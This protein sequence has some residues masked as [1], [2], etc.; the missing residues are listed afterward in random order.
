M[1]LG[2]RKDK[3]KALT[4]DLRP[5]FK[6]TTEEYQSEI[7]DLLK[8]V[9]KVKAGVLEPRDVAVVNNLYDNLHRLRR[10]IERT[11]LSEHVSNTFAKTAD[12]VKRSPIG[13]ISTLEE[14]GIVLGGVS[15]ERVRQIES[16]AIKKLKH[17]KVGRRIRNY[18]DIGDKSAPLSGN[19][20][21]L[22]EVFGIR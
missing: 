10:K 19:T 8:R 15:R 2:Y 13:D 12:N 9:E 16:G 21:A 6:R 5:G 3:F 22:L 1:V 7:E 20:D 17:P 11:I 18:L 4:F 14:C